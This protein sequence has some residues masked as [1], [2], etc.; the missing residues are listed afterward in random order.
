MET[1][2]ASKAYRTE[3]RNI[4]IRTADGSTIRGRVN[5]GVKERVSDL[6]TKSESP[7][8]IVTDATHKE[9]AGK[10]LFVNKSHIVWAEPEN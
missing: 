8:V 9:G 3:M 10:T 7:F 4:V 6:F 1:E 2:K 5:L